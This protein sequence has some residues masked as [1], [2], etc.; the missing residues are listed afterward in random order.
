MTGWP[1]WIV[2]IAA[3]TEDD[4]KNLA[5]PGLVRRGRRLV[6]SGQVTLASVTPD[7]VSV[8]VGPDTSV[9]L[10]PGGPKT[11]RCLCPVAGVCIHLVAAFI[12]VSTHVEVS[13]E[14]NVAATSSD[15][16]EPEPD[17]SAPLPLTPPQRQVA[18][19]VKNAIEALVNTGLSYSSRADADRLTRMAERVRLEQLPLLSRLLATAAGQE[20]QVTLTALAEAWGLAYALVASEGPLLARL[21]GQTAGPRQP[22]QPAHTG[23]LVP[24]SLRW[25]HDASGSRGFTVRMWD[26]DHHRLEIVTTGRA[27]GADPSFAF[28]WHGPLLWRSSPERLSS[29]PFRLDNAERRDDGTLNP[30]DRTRIAPESSFA[31]LDWDALATAVNQHHHHLDAVGFGRRIPPLTLIRPA[32]R[33]GIGRLHLDEIA[34]EL[35]WT[36]IDANGVHHLLRI[37]VRDRAAEFF[38]TVM[39]NE[40]PIRAVI[41]EGDRPDA[42]LVEHDDTLQLWSATMTPVPTP[43]VHAT[44]LL[45]A[46]RQRLE[47]F[48]RRVSSPLTTPPS[49]PHPVRDL[50]GAV[51]DVCEALAASGRLT[52]TPRQTDALH[53]RRQ[54]ADELGLRTLTAAVA[55]LTTNPNAETVLKTTLLAD[56]VLA[57]AV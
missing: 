53:R 44:G 32:P 24:L 8:K 4:L 12:W 1:D 3:L 50:C 5:N 27:A 49:Q 43:S 22:H 17:E 41:V 16:A 19:D 37:A 56:R 20:H 54:Q 47:D 30:T 11:A 38:T 14:L 40:T 57:L 28:T 10:L 46:W 9:R 36:I 25:W 2:E 34:Q 55:E 29:R 39:A 42:V 52:L 6:E 26:A 51:L 35:T 31:D 48:R 23:L 21:V 18:R 7:E 13:P 33:T 15:P 45:D